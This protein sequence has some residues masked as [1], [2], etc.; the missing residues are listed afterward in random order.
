METKEII[1]KILENREFLITHGL[2]KRTDTL[3][4]AMAQ[5][6]EVLQ[7]SE[8]NIHNWLK[9]PQAKEIAMKVCNG[10]HKKIKSL[11]QN[12]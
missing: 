7:W 11:I 8:D 2:S 1:R 9:K 12:Y 10:N 4:Q 5:L 6:R 3:Q